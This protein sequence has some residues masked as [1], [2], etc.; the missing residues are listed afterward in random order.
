[1]KGATSFYVV[2]S[3]AW[4]AAG[5]PASSYAQQTVTGHDADQTDQTTPEQTSAAAGQTTDAQAGQGT[6]QPRTPI[7]PI[8]EADRAAAFP[9]V[10]GDTVRDN[11]V[12][13]FV[14]FDQLEWQSVETGGGLHWDTKG[15]VGRDRDRLWFRT[16]GEAEDGRLG[17]GE[18]HV[19]YGRAFARWWGRGGGP[20]PGHPIW[21]RTDLGR[22]RCA[23][24]R[25]VRVRSGSNRLYQ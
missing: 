1:M 17:K 16:E 7:P 12:H 6:T 22:V 19:F 9:A 4:L 21:A 24:A 5:W 18:A 2:I 25:P 20:P 8:T 15:W 14:L 11:A 13:Y 23:G 10:E 3:I